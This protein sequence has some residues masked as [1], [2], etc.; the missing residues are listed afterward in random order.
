MAKSPPYAAGAEPG[1]MSPQSSRAVIQHHQGPRHRQ[2]QGRAWRRGPASIPLLR[3]RP[4]EV[5]GLPVVP[6]SVRGCRERARNGHL[7]VRSRAARRR[8][9]RKGDF[10][11]RSVRGTDGSGYLRRTQRSSGRRGC[12]RNRER[13]ALLLHHRRTTS[14]QAWRAVFRS[15]TLA[16]SGGVSLERLCLSARDANKDF[17][18]KQ[19]GSVYGGRGGGGAGPGHEAGRRPE[20]GWRRRR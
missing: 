3:V 12:H 7:P 18:F 11:G 4:R 14:A 9:K 2:G 16:P 1:R 17:F 5:G 6:Q 20:G 13:P 15:R 10:C 19:T 8:P